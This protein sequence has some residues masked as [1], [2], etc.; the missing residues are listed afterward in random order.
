MNAVVVVC[1]VLLLAGGVIALRWRHL[2]LVAPWV[3]DADDDLGWK[4]RLRRTAWYIVVHV[5]AALGSGLLVV[6]PGGR[7]VM[8]LLAVTSGDDA[9][10]KLT[11]AKEV[12]GEIT[13]GGTIGFIVFVG[14]GGGMLI[15]V[16]SA[17]ARKWLPPGRLGALALA[18]GAAVVFSTRLEPL[19]PDNEDFAI[20]GPP[21]LAVVTFL[22]LG[23]LA[24]LTFA[25]IAGRLGRSLPLLTKRP[26]VL[27]CYLPLVL[28]LLLGVGFALGVAVVALAVSLLAQ[29]WFRKVW[30]NRRV[31]IGGRLAL[32]AVV[33]AFLPSFIGD[34]TEILGTDQPSATATETI[35]DGGGLSPSEP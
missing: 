28:I 1:I 14:L 23:L 12:V 25:A 4:E 24:F 13:V 34:V 6:G 33:V 16:L 5:G 31:T 18:F 11:E 29:P 7:L 21:W 32:A 22:G 27:V 20:V 30:S 3:D 19:R 9:Q 10:G 26:R 2:R 17:A 8:R 35:G 15:A